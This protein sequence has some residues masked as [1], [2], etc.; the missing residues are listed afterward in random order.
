M[1]RPSALLIRVSTS[2]C[3]F[4]LVLLLVRMWRLK[5][6]LRFTFPVAVLRNRLAAPRLVFILGMLSPYQRL[7]GAEGAGGAGGAAPVP[8]HFLGA[9][10]MSR[11]RPSCRGSVSTTPYSPISFLIRSRMR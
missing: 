3:R 9:R 4:L 10:I 5:A 6:R 11:K 7:A 2:R 8:A 1:R